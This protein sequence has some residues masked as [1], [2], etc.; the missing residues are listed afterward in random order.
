[1]FGILCNG[2][3]IATIDKPN[4]AVNYLIA[5]NENTAIALCKLLDGKIGEVRYTIIPD[6]E[7]QRFDQYKA[8][9]ED[10]YSDI[11]LPGEGKTLYNMT[12]QDLCEGFGEQ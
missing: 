8:K 1:M 7:P 6:E 4:Q 2:Q 12:S 9:V 10:D 11:H 5:K 3:P